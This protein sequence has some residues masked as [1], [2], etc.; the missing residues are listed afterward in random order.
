MIYRLNIFLLYFWSEVKNGVDINFLRQLSHIV[1]LMN[2][3]QDFD[4][5]YKG[6]EP[7]FQGTGQQNHTYIQGYKNLQKLLQKQF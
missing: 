7:C 4:Y 2:R 1:L 3:D 5:V 6:E